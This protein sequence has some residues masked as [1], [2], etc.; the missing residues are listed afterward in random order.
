[1]TISTTIADEAMRNGLVLGRIAYS[2]P[3]KLELLPQNDVLPHI[4]EL[5][6]FYDGPR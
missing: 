3:T 1:M 5:P 4:L 2:R 6:K